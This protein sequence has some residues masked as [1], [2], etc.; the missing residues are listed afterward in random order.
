MVR[1][2]TVRAMSKRPSP[3]AGKLVIPVSAILAI[4]VVA[5]TINPERP[6]HQPP[7]PIPP[8]GDA[9][10]LSFP[11]ARTA[12]FSRFTAL[13]SLQVLAPSDFERARQSA[14]RLSSSWWLSTTNGVTL[15]VSYGALLRRKIDE[16][17]P[18]YRASSHEY[19]RLKIVPTVR[20]APEFTK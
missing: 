7:L 6:N 11:A 12:L 16:E 5:V 10:A 15:L 19:P 8:G 17:N 18:R 1:T 9:M 4:A 3:G 13:C 20:P 14:R 2:A